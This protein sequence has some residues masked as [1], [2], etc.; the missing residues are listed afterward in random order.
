MIRKFFDEQLSLS[1]SLVKGYLVIELATFKRG[2]RYS[3][4]GVKESVQRVNA[5]HE[6]R[7]IHT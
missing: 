2:T 5:V 1:E 4:A 7:V 3:R 6:L